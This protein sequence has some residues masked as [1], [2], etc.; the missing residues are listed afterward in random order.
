MA[1]VPTVT[2]VKASGFAYRNGLSSPMAG[3]FAW[4]RASFRSDTIPANAGAAAEVPAI[5][6]H[7]PFINV[8]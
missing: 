4:R 2:S 1:F 3:I 7:L 8:W 6:D 5:A